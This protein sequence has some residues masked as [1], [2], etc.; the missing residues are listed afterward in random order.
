MIDTLALYAKVVLV[1]LLTMAYLPF[2]L[3]AIVS[4]TRYGWLVAE[5]RFFSKYGGDIP[6]GEVEEEEAGDALQRRKEDR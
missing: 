3:G 5:Y 4:T 2:I 1:L 6:N